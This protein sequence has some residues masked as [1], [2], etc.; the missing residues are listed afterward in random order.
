MVTLVA[1]DILKEQ[2]MVVEKVLVK[3]NEDIEKGEVCYNDGNGWLAA[4]NTLCG[5]KHG[6]ALV[7]HDYSAVSYHYIQMLFFGLIVVQK[8]SGTAIKKGQ[9]VTVGATAG[10]VTLFVC[11]DPPTGSSS[12][13]YTTTIE[14][15]I[16]D[17]MEDNLRYVGVCQQDAG[18][19]DTVVA[20][21]V[22]MH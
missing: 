17:A 14:Q 15:G 10:E 4:P 16:L 12:T 21:W 18:S 13:Y 11:G 7:A 20:V 6:V 2:L 22:G 8:I 3:S 19:S 1:G 5:T 9:Y